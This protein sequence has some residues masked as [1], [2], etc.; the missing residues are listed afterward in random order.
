M[1]FDSSFMLPEL[2]PPKDIQAQVYGGRIKSIYV[3]VEFEDVNYA[4]L[5]G[6]TYN[7]VGKLLEDPIDSFLVGF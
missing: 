5:A 3:N 4:L 2:R 1:D 6:N 7:E